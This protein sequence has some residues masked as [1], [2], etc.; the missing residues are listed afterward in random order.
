M[1]QMFFFDE[2]NR[3]LCFMHAV[4]QAMKGDDINTHIEDDLEAAEHNL[5]P[6]C[7]IHKNEAAQEKTKAHEKVVDKSCV[8]C[9]GDKQVEVCSSCYPSKTKQIMQRTSS[10]PKLVKCPLCG[11]RNINLIECPL[12]QKGEK[13]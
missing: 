4:K 5:F 2:M 3:Q 10:Y 8:I 13:I 6:E 1:L 9:G 11:K 7:Y 12:C